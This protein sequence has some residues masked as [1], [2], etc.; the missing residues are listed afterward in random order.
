[1]ITSMKQ[2]SRQRLYQIKLRKEKP[3]VYYEQK[4]RNEKKYHKTEKYKKYAR[5]YMRRY[6]AKKLFP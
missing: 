2:L 5:E 4:R 1:M 3:A 6:R